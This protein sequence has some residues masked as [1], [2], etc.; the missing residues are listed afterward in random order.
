MV[1]D[2]EVAFHVGNGLVADDAE[3]FIDAVIK[4]SGRQKKT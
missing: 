4:S 1:C 3:K 2:A